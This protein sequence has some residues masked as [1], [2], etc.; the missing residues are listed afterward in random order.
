M[1]ELS[2]IKTMNTKNISVNTA[3]T[4]VRID[5]I[6]SA[7]TKH[8][9]QRAVDIGGYTDTRSFNKTRISGLI[10]VRMVA[11]LSLALNIDPFYINAET[12]VNTGCDEEKIVRFV[13]KYGFE[14]LVNNEV[15]RPS[16]IEVVNFVSKLIDG[17]TS[18]KRAAINSLTNEELGVLLNSY[19]IRARL[20][21]DENTRLFLLKALLTC[22]AK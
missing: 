8:Q 16:K 12:D 6:W 5:E 14:N 4:K 18:E 13:S 22:D 17:I 10:S 11:A 20:G 2:L 9:K 7:T 15:E 1:I 19:L 3:V 21:N